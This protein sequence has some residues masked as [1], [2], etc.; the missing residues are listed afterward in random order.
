MENIGAVINQIIK[1]PPALSRG[2]LAQQRPASN[3]QES[4]TTQTAAEAEKKNEFEVSSRD[5]AKYGGAEAPDPAT[6]E[7]CGA[8]LYCKGILNF[9]NKRDVMIWFG[10]PDRCTCK[11]ATA[12]WEE[13]DAKKEAD[14]IE[15]ER[16]EK[17]S[18]M[19]ARVNKLFKDSGIRGR[20]RNRTFDKFTVNKENRIAYTAA[21]K[22]ADTFH[23]RLPHKDERGVVMPPTIERNGLLMIGSYGTGKTHLTAAIANQLMQTGIPVIAMTMIDLLARIKQSYDDT[24]RVSEAEV[25]K[26]YEDIPLLV[27]DDIGSEQPTEWGVTRIYTI[28]NARY[29]AYMPTIITTNYGTPELIQRMT[30]SGYGKGGDSHNAEKTIDRLMEMCECVEMFWESWRGK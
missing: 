17:D 2:E 29:E 19:Q 14:R 24:D 4:R 11:K 9:Q 12:Y 22:Y 10:E 21:K 18:R 6:C 23:D 3:S 25:I 8:T 28:I 7:F 5:A 20:F 27:I 26:I 15:Q 30:P 1:N 13:V 16:R